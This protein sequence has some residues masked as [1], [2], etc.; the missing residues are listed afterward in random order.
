MD[1]VSHSDM[2]LKDVMAQPHGAHVDMS[3]IVG[4]VGAAYPISRLMEL[5]MCE[6]GKFYLLFLHETIV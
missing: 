5:Y 6:K 4:F 1:Q 2:T 3:A